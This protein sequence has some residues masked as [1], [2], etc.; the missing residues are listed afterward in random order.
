ITWKLISAQA[1]KQ[2]EDWRATFMNL[3][4]EIAPDPNML[5]FGDEA[6]KD[7][8]TLI[9]PYGRA[10]K[11]THCG[12][13]YSIVPILTLDGIITYDIVKGSVTSDCFI[14]FLHERLPLTN[15]FPGPQSVLILDNY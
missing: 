11:S 2:N 10:H 13:H 8:H 3:I 4:A 1:L 7:E 15:P 9:R 6:A 5:M 12:T 14:Q